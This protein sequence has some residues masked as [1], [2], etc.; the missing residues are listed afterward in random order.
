VLEP[1]IRR[2]QTPGLEATDGVAVALGPARTLPETRL[3][4]GLMTD[5][6]CQV[7]LALPARAAGLVLAIGMRGGP[8]G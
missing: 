6:F 7:C 4:S 8:R 5:G 1:S 3:L 2:D